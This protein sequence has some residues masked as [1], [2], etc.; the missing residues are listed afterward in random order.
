MELFPAIDLLGGQVVRLYQGDYGKSKVFGS[1]PLAFARDFEQKGAKNLHLVDL[2][3]AKEGTPKN[4]DVVKSIAQNT[5]LFI[6]LGGGIRDEDA[7]KRC[8]DA[9]VGRVILGTKALKDKAFTQ[10]M[11]QRY[12]DKIAIGVDARDGKV[13]VEGWLETSSVDSYEFCGAM[14]EIGAKYI[15][16]TDISR[17]G[18]MQG[19]NVELYKTLSEIKGVCFTASGGVSSLG[20]IAALGQAGLYAAILGKALYTGAVELTA[21]LAVAEQ[22]DTKESD[23]KESV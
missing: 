23:T 15:I 22:S 3:G 2:D 17:D 9:G 13:A 8:F 5:G 14:G 1:D 16:Y 4:F 7:V 20:D 12:G 18:A 6:E 21:A 11:I 19:I 10:S